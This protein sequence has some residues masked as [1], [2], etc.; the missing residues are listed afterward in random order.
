[1]FVYVDTALPACK[2][3][4]THITEHMWKLEKTLGIDQ[5]FLRFSSLYLSVGAS[6]LHKL[7]VQNVFIWLREI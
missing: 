3:E 2:C 5:S 1:M 4:P 6:G 7:M